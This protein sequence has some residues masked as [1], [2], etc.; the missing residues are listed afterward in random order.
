MKLLSVVLVT[1]LL[2]GGGVY[3]WMKNAQKTVAP[4]PVTQTP[5]VTTT[6][7]DKV[8]VIIYTEEIKDTDGEGRSWPTVRIMKKVGSAA[9]ELLADNIGKVGEYAGAYALSSDHKTLYINLESKLQTLDLATKKLTNFF[10]P[11]KQVSSFKV[12]NDGKYMYVWDQIYASTTD[13][14][15]YLHRLDLTTNTDTILK[16]GTLPDGTYISIVQ[17]RSDGIL[18]LMQSLG[19]AWAPWTFNLATKE[20]RTVPGTVGGL[21]GTSGAGKYLSLS[22]D[23]VP[24]MCDDFFGALPSMYE[25]LDSYTGNKVDTF[26][27]KG[28]ATDI[29]GYSPDDS[30]VLFS[31]Y[32]SMEKGT[33]DDYKQTTKECEAYAPVKTYYRM[34]IGSGKPVLVTD[35]QAIL[36][37][38]HPNGSTNFDAKYVTV[39][40][41]AQ[42]VISYKGTEIF[43]PTM[44]QQMIE[45]FEE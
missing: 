5:I 37:Q 13:Y 9:P 15:Y 26:G 44:K 8:P 31:S 34:V 32:Q 38:W 40:N 20:L 39:G 18:V 21:Q 7:E 22:T 36:D 10:T 43:K 23:D 35:Y 1:A 29:L 11:K 2:V 28:K 14:G 41:N 30:E 25:L 6:N 12:S 24:S 33:T 19:E 17:E 42:Y 3:F 45:S 27:I 16:Q 4:A